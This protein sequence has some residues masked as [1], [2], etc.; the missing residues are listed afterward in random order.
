MLLRKTTL[1]TKITIGFMIVIL[2]MSAA[3]GI[4]LLGFRRNEAQM[5]RL[6]RLSQE[7]EIAARLETTFLENRLAFRTYQ[8]IGEL[9]TT[10]GDAQFTIDRLV[11][12]FESLTD[13][14][15]RLRHMEDIHSLLSLYNRRFGEL[16]VLGRELLAV[17]GELTEKGDLLVTELGALSEVALA[18]EHLEMFRRVHTAE[19][20]LLLARRYATSYVETQGATSYALFREHFDAFMVQIAGVGPLADRVGGTDRY[21]QVRLLMA[22]YDQGMHLYHNQAR[23]YNNL[24][25]RMGTTGEQVSALIGA[26]NASIGIESA[27]L[28]SAASGQ[29]RTKGLMMGLMAALAI[30]TALLVARGLSRQILDPIGT[31]T[32]EFDAIA[33]GNAHA[34]FR[35]STRLQDEIGDMSRAFN[36]FMDRIQALFSE[37][38]HRAKVVTLQHE[39]NDTMRREMDLDALIRV[40]LEQVVDHFEGVSGAF[41]LVTHEGDYRLVSRYGVPECP[42][43][44]IRPGEGLLGITIDQGQGR[45]LETTEVMTTAFSTGTGAGLAPYLTLQPTLYEDSPNG[46]IEIGR[47]KAWSEEERDTLEKAVEEI[48]DVLHT[49]FLSEEMKWLLDR[50]TRQAERL[51][52]QQEELRQNNEELEQQAQSLM[53]SENELLAQQEEL[54][55]S[56]EELGARSKRLE[57]QQWVL[58]QKNRELLD[59]YQEVLDKKV[60]LEEA[61]RHRT[62]FFANMSHELRTPLNS[63]L[64]LSELLMN[65]GSQD[66]LTAKEG[67]FAETIHR[68]GR[69]LLRMIDD[70]LDLSKI[71][72]GKVEFVHEPFQLSQFLLDHERLFGPMAEV[73]HLRFNAFL[74]EGLPETVA[75]DQYRI[76]QIVKNLLSNA[77]KFTK[78]G[79]VTLGIRPVA[80]HEGEELALNPKRYFA[81]DVEDTG[82]GIPEDKRQLVFDAFRQTDGTTS[83]EYGGTGLGLAISRQ[84]AERLGGHL[85]LKKSSEKGSLFTLILPFVAQSE[86]LENAPSRPLHLEKVEEQRPGELKPVDELLVVTHDE[87]LQ[88]A[89][90]E[91]IVQQNMTAQSFSGA[92]ESMAYL[93]KVLP[94]AILLDPNV[95]DA[96]PDAFQHKIE[97]V[98]DQTGVPLHL[99]AGQS[100]RRSDRITEILRPPLQIKDVYRTLAAVETVRPD[101]QTRLLVVG[102]CEGETFADFEKLGDCVLTRVETGEEMFEILKNRGA[103]VLIIDRSLDEPSALT[104]VKRLDD[105]GHASLPIVLYASGVEEERIFEEAIDKAGKMTKAD[106][107]KRMMNEVVLFLKSLG[108][109]VE[110][111]VSREHLEG[112]SVLV[113][114]DDERNLFAM[115]HLLEGMGM[116]VHTASDGYEALDL[117]DHHPVDL[118]LIDMMMPKKDGLQTLVEIRKKEGK[119]HMPILALSAKTMQE[120]RKRA[121]EAGADD[122]LTKPV[123]VEQLVATM[124][125]WLS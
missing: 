31:L 46:L 91:A 77:I 67:E 96:T 72:A 3:L 104:L 24:V 29:M 34:T 68:S 59:V 61:N 15:S 117:L 32:R 17:S 14:P 94:R 71:E 39:L 62:E 9:P 7:S 84:L 115:M 100:P 102:D 4:G 87:D 47:L 49:V 103:E 73:H 95:S 26:I 5:T 124:K 63:I 50:T 51:Q 82:I 37:A 10:E 54:R 88:S 18:A 64:V 40:L 2:L 16:T 22:D 30:G 86:T 48:G 122:Y 21:T 53:A 12:S 98:L 85:M 125:V 35:L 111:T 83:R 25:A 56:N 70:V 81:V 42:E 23:I 1:R 28:L 109:K 58:D 38:E 108:R 112:R 19:I 66:A 55:V 107:H 41:Y 13:N 57:E 27:D 60:A 11:D 105:A 92:Q 76:S 90:L 36:R 123:A 69:D 74:A 33:S 99:L 75:L 97:R 20:E 120:D 43:E 101:E 45:Y 8:A 65:K 116:T 114:D 6:D 44:I 113:V 121:L 110:G 93:E 79:T 80:G 78:H 106:R 89:I 118:L 52:Q 119:G